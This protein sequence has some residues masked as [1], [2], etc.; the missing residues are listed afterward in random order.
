ME[1]LV[2]MKVSLCLLKSRL[3]LEEGAKR[4]F[5]MTTYA[6]YFVKRFVMLSSIFDLQNLMPLES[7]G[8]TEMGFA[9]NFT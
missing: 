5:L 9:D 8:S 1:I 7:R 3:K 6:E 2:P 4:F